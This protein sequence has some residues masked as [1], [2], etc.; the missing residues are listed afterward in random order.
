MFYRKK[1]VNHALERLRIGT[2]CA[3]ACYAAYLFWLVPL[4][5]SKLY[6]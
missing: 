6:I 2:A 3:A 1:N 4:N 5:I